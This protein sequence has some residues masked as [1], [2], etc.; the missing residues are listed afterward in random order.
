MGYRIEIKLTRKDNAF[1]DVGF[2]ADRGGRPSLVLRMVFHVG[3][4]AG[5]AQQHQ[6][7][8]AESRP[9]MC[10]DISGHTQ[11]YTS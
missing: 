4:K 6:G 1:I 3:E 8:G 2:G 11:W 7:E 10:Q 5:G 9:S